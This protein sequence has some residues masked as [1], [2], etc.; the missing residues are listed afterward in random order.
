MAHM[1]NVVSDFNGH[2]NDGPRVVFNGHMDTFPVNNLEGWR[3]PPYSGY[4]DGT[5]IHGLGSVDMKAGTAASI[6]AFTLL[7]KRASHLVGSVALTV[8]SDEE[9]G[10]K[11]GT[12][13]LLDHCD[14]K[15]PWLGDCV[16]KGGPGGLQS[17]RFGKKG[18]IH[19]SFEAIV[20][21]ACLMTILKHMVESIRANVPPELGAYLRSDEVR[22]VTDEIMGSGAAANM[23]SPTLNV[24]VIH[25]GVKVNMISSK[26][27]FE[28]DIRL[29]IG[30][31]A[32]AVL[33][34]IDERLLLLFPSVSYSIQ[35]AASDPASF[36]GFN[37]P[38]SGYMSDVA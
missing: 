26:C 24:G 1:P 23:L 33:R 15:L 21:A 29:P 18:R 9:T 28:A 6:I 38:L 7:K 36:S 3:V 35:E 14:E 30:L 5:S 27:V 11:W 32:E 10:G 34:N 16:M 25:G 8:V 12:K 13:Y 22:A 19:N 2:L 20:Y 4:N 17:I 31:K 37:H